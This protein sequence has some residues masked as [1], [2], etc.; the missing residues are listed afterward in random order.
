M[1]VQRNMLVKEV[2]ILIH[3][4]LSVLVHDGF[5]FVDRFGKIDVDNLFGIES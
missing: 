1:I 3:F 5:I 2:I 4:N